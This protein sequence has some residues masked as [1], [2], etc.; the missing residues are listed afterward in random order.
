MLIEFDDEWGGDDG[1]A[2]EEDAF[3][4]GGVGAVGF[5]EDDDFLRKGKRGMLVFCGLEWDGTGE[6][7]GGGFSYWDCV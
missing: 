7:E 5:G 6:R 3:G 2:L 4:F 1:V